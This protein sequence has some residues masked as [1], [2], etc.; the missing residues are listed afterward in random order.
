MRNRYGGIIWGNESNAI[1]YDQWW[2]NRN[3][4]TYVFDPSNPK[5]PARII[6]DRN[7]QDIYS[8]PGDFVTEKGRYGEFILSLQK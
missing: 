6:N 1:I 3:S 2:D 8:D 4:K 7:Y 5:I